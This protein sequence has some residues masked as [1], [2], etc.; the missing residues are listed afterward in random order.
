MD[1]YKKFISRKFVNKCNNGRRQ[2]DRKYG[3]KKEEFEADF[4]S[5][6]KVVEKLSTKKWQKNWVFDFYYCVIFCIY[7][8]G[9]EL[10]MKCLKLEKNNLFF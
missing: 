4:E 7:F 10:S 2:I 3:Y 1:K 9:F 5:V 8:K 6:E